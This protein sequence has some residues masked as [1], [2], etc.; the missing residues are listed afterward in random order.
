MPPAGGKSAGKRPPK[1]G[2]IGAAVLHHCLRQQA[3]NAQRHQ[4][5]IQSLKESAAES[6]ASGTRPAGVALGGTISRHRTLEFL[7]GSLTTALPSKG[8]AQ[9]KHTEQ[10]LRSVIERSGLDDYL[11]TALA[12]QDTFSVD[13]H[14]ARLFHEPTAPSILAAKPMEELGRGMGLLTE[15]EDVHIPRRPIFFSRG[16]AET[17]KEV[18]H[19]GRASESMASRN[20]RRRNRAR[21]K[22]LLAGKVEEATVHNVQFVRKQRDELHRR[23]QKPKESKSN[24]RQGRPA[25]SSAARR[26]PETSGRW[27]A[28]SEGSWDSD[29]TPQTVAERARAENNG[30]NGSES[31]S[32]SDSSLT[33]RAPT[34]NSTDSEAE[35]Q[36]APTNE[37]E[38]SPHLPRT[39]AELEEVELDSFLQWRRSLAKLEDDGIVLTPYEKNLEVWR[40]L[41]RS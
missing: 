32:E 21:V 20:R 4:A 25:G 33:R 10:H 7:S 28:D 37:P 12:A 31:D 22:L 13:R 39:A 26:P 36:N 19:K 3:E 2:G 35:E 17:L 1:N 24:K 23:Y 38:A 30:M 15:G 5:L 27:G 14:E 6:P 16:K 40:Q 8:S 41:W 11:S 9:S 34:P 29:A 18:E